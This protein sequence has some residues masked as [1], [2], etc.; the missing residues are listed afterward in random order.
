MKI[1]LPNGTVLEMDDTPSRVK[2]VDVVGEHTSSGD[3][4]ATEKRKETHGVQTA[5]APTAKEKTETAPVSK[6]AETLPEPA[7]PK[8]MPSPKPPAVSSSGNFANQGGIADVLDPNRG[9]PGYFQ[10]VAPKEEGR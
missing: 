8:A 9:K 6:V 4:V 2:Q 7:Q 3:P 5:N 1:T 10:Y